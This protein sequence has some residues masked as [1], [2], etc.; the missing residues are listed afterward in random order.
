MR[1]SAEICEIAN[2]IEG[3]HICI[4]ILNKLDF[5]LLVFSFKS[6]NCVRAL[7]FC[8][9]KWKCLA[10]NL[11]HFFL[12]LF[13]VLRTERLLSEEI[14]IETVFNGRAYCN[15]Y[16]GAKNFSN[17]QCHNMGSRVS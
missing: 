3:D 10:H 6:R 17:G 4:Q 9:T 5:I 13:K 14:V 8:S 1:S 2:L 12:Y 7:N 11:F 15:F 16:I